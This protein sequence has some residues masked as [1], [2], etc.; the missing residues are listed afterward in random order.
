[1]KFL[2]LS[3]FLWVNPLT[4]VA[5]M[6]VMRKDL[7]MLFQ[8][9]RYDLAEQKLNALLKD[10]K[11][12]TNEVYLN[13]AHIYF[14]KKNK[15]KALLYYDK[16]LQNANAEI[17]SIAFNQLGYMSALR[18]NLPEALQLFKEAVIR[19]PNNQDARYN[20]ELILKVIAKNPQIFQNN[21]KNNIANPNNSDTLTKISRLNPNI[22]GNE[23]GE[24]ASAQGTKIS[25]NGASQKNMLSK[26]KAENILQTLRNQETQYLQQKQK[27]I[28]KIN[29]N[30]VGLPEW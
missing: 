12:E 13:L 15:E 6:N 5:E 24:K 7:E 2:L 21:T 9:Q 25:E 3:I 14:L 19:Y 17:Q 10:Y 11:S 20:Y 8:K 1:M 4:F 27:N 22:Q 29:P 16:V 26:E 23:Q 28:K 18:Q 30:H